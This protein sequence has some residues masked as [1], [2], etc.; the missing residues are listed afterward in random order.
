MN[1][2]GNHKKGKRGRKNSRKN[3]QSYE[4]SDNNTKI[5]W[6]AKWNPT[7]FDYYPSQIKDSLS[8][9]YSKDIE[10]NRIRENH[11]DDL[12]SPTHYPHLNSHL[13]YPVKTDR[14]GRVM[15]NY[16]YYK[17]K[18]P[19]SHRI[20]GNDDLEV[21]H[22]DWIWI[23]SYSRMPL[24][25]LKSFCRAAI[26]YCPPGIPGPIGPQGIKGDRGS[27]GSMGEKGY[28]GI[29]GIDGE[30]GEQGEKGGRGEIGFPGIPGVNGEPG[31]KG[32]KG[33]IGEPGREGKDGLPG[34]PGEAGMMGLPG[35]NGKDG[36]PGWPGEPGPPGPLGPDG[37]TGIKGD[38]GE[39][40]QDGLHGLNGFPGRRG[41]PG[42]QGEPGEKGEMGPP[43][44][45][46]EMGPQGPPGPRGISG[47]PGLVV[48]QSPVITI[49]FVKKP[50]A[51]MID[52]PY[53]RSTIPPRIQNCLLKAVGKPVFMRYTGTYWG[54]WMR[55]PFPLTPLDNQKIWMTKHF[56][57]KEVFE[58]ANEEAF[59][60]D[61]ISKTYILPV[62]YEG[63]SHQVMSGSL[64]YH[65]DDSPTVG[66]YDFKNE[67]LEET[68]DLPLATYKSE[69]Y[70]FS[71]E[72]NYFDFNVDET[73]LYVIYRVQDSGDYILVA[74]LKE[75]GVR[76]SSVEG[77]KFDANTEKT[78][79]DHFVS[80]Y[81]HYSYEDEYEYLPTFKQVKK[82]RVKRGEIKNESR[83]TSANLAQTNSNTRQTQPAQ[84]IK[85]IGPPTIPFV[86]NYETPF[87]ILKMWN[88][89]LKYR[90]VGNAFMICGIIY[91]L[92]NA[93][94]EHT[95]IDFAYDL[96]ENEQ[97]YLIIPFD[98]PYQK[99]TMLSYNSRDKS[100]Y[101]WDRGNQLIYPLRFEK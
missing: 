69:S 101:S 80:R 12:T 3:R 37:A 71:G 95:V 21:P 17:P 56:D 76:E 61:N 4:T 19:K 63:N 34:R 83:E 84:Y 10:N 51:K 25:T 46:G 53:F 57:G 35:M 20:E 70:L 75:A 89:T 39:R 42:F 30:K 28:R 2:P 7:Y 15:Q 96:Y 6:G 77:T 58:Y 8:P 62:S 40:G 66:R 97:I 52:I 13:N 98:N 55:D 11:Y 67:K 91:G 9:S 1:E 87:E 22:N 99:T 38:K 26:E 94:I 48:E 18:K 24:S 85:T 59:K 79:N 78:K 93:E 33:D 41:K 90:F 64:Y 50:T 27:P 92:K 23:S 60:A 16:V 81:L 31:R 73:G 5:K 72:Y 45:K 49:P 86:Q 68:I 82:I 47:V 54:T 43:G 100:L 36:V 88:I 74:K 32:F 14:D 65:L 44:K 29:P